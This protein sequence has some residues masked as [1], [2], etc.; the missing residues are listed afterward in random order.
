MMHFC[1]MVLRRFVAAAWMLR[2]AVLTFFA[3]L[4]LASLAESIGLETLATLL[5]IQTQFL[6]GYVI[7][8]TVA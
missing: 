5:F 4:G 2:W 6:T 7:A 1:N 8:K 3:G